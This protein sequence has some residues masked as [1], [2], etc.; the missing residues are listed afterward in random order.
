MDLPETALLDRLEKA[1]KA[2]QAALI[3]L[4]LAEDALGELHNSDGLHQVSWAR[5]QFSVATGNYQ[6]ALKSFTDFALGEAGKRAKDLGA[7]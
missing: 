4:R 3:D 5:H 6:E 1:R 2:Y 7:G